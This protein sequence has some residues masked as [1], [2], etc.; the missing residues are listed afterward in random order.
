[1]GSAMT[2]D[3]HRTVIFSLVEAL[4][5]LGLMAFILTTT[6]T[7]LVDTKDIGEIHWRR[8]Q[9]Q[10]HLYRFGEIIR[11]DLSRIW[12]PDDATESLSAITITHGDSPVDSLA[13]ITIEHQNGER[14]LHEVEYLCSPSTEHEEQVSCFRRFADFDGQ[15]HA[16]GLYERVLDSIS[17]LDFTYFTSEGWTSMP[18][19]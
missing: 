8:S 6:S 10:S 3:Y 4:I 1:M 15:L 5:S 13:F 9:A 16:G 11:E 17:M 7:I 14:V 2:T 12:I 18:T 19:E